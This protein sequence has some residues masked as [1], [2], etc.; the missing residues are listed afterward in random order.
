MP[1]FEMIIFFTLCIALFIG[2]MYVTNHRFCLEHYTV[3]SRKIPKNFDGS[4]MIL[5]TDLHNH[6]FGK[7]NS[8]LLEAIKN[9]N[10][11]YIMV[12]GDLLIKGENFAT[13]TALNLLEQLSRKYPVYYVPGNHE[14]RLGEMGETKND[15]WNGYIAKIK[16]MGVIYLLN[17]TVTLEKENQKIY[18][19]GADID[20]VYYK[21]GFHRKKLEKEEL[22]RILPIDET[23][24]KY[25]VL[26]AHNPEYFEAYA[27]WG[28]D[29]VLSGHVHGGIMILPLVGGVVAPSYQLFPKYD[30]GMFRAGESTMILSRGLAVHSIKIRIFNIPELSVITLKKDNS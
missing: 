17:E 18:V 3:T 30:F 8:K 12:A 28:A 19:S 21:K 29:L 1:Y 6:S 10:P 24:Q 27:A 9:E 20:G 26:L 22:D 5:I 16:K 14:K 4:K 13:E 25:R 23:E 15:F 2:W 11:D 7:K